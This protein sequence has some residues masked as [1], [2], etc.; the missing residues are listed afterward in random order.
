MNVFFYIKSEKAENLSTRLNFL[1]R[2]FNMPW[3]TICH[4]L[5]MRYEFSWFDD[6]NSATIKDMKNLCTKMNHTGLIT[7]QR[8]F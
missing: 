5:S 8:K 4:Q 6:N 7:P 2:F 3:F 1:D